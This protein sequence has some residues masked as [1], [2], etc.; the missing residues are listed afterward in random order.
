LDTTQLS[1]DVDGGGALMCTFAAPADQDDVV[2]QINLS[3]LGAALTASLDEG[4]TGVGPP[5]FLVLT[6]NTTGTTSSLDVQAA[7]AE[8]LLG[9]AVVLVTGV[10]QA[11]PTQRSNRSPHFGRYEILDVSSATTLVVPALDASVADYSQYSTPVARQTYKIERVGVQR[12]CTTDMADNDAEA[13]LYYFDVELVSEGTGDLWNIDSVQQMTVTDYRSDGYYLTTDDP[14]LTFSETEDI[15]MILSRS[16]LEEGVDDSPVNATQLS[17]QNAQVSYDRSELVL[18]VQNFIGAD[19]ER[20]VC[21]SPLARHLIPY[22]VRF[23]MNYI[24]GSSEDV[25]VPEI[26]TYI[27]D[28]F[29]IDNMEVSD[30]EAIVTNRGATSITNPIDLIALVHF[31]DRTIYIERSQDALGVSRLASF[32]PDILDVTRSLA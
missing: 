23:D 28:L 1:V 5:S 4:F 2:T 18:D 16:I 20:V 14:N 11:N 31:T 3:A 12:I 19:V 25:V 21:S 6:S 9:I 13:S 22:F 15:K 8:A 27:R 32:I 24:G 10:D 26:E 29:P 7:T 30:L 17:G